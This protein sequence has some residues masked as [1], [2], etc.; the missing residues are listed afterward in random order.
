MGFGIVVTAGDRL[1]AMSDDLLRWLVEARVELELSEP[2]RFALRFED[3]LCDGSFHVEGAP[4]I[5]QNA[6]IGLFLP[7]N[8]E[9][10]C[11]VYGP[12]TEIRSS[13]TTG[14]AGSW[15]EARGVSRLVEMDRI[16]VQAAYTGLASGAAAGILS[17]YGFVADCQD[18]L[19]EYDEQR[20]Q[21]TQR[22]TDLSFLQDIARR[23]NMELWLEY[24]AIQGPTDVILTENAKLRTSPERNQEIGFPAPAVLEAPTDRRLRINPPRDECPSVTRFEV[25]IDYEK[26]TAA[27]GFAMSEDAAQGLVQQILGP[28]ES[29]DPERPVQVDGVQRDVIAPPEVTDEEAFLAQDSL[30]TEQSWF[31]EIEASGSL[32]Q[33]GFV[34]LP[35]QIVEVSHAGRRLSGTYQVT[36]ATHVVTA[37]ERLVDFKLRANGLGEAG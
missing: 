11:L 16:G 33:I 30:V 31:V 20:I 1:E 10:T 15:I 22:G 17:A 23:N 35:H 34:V 21:L 25:N 32:E 12:I 19:I 5:A 8:D 24:D 27:Q 36:E 26:P 13:T 28:A 18:T 14:G 37:T 29:L 6:Y 3:D 7:E 4:Q 2:S 9:L